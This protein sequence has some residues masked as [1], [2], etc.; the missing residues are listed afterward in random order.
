M[1]KSLIVHIG[2]HK[3]GSTAIQNALASGRIVDSTREVHYLSSPPGSLP[4]QNFLFNALR[5]KPQRSA[6]AH[7]RSMFAEIRRSDAP[8]SVISAEVLERVPA[9]AFAE[10]LQRE[11]RGAV[12]DVRIVAYC[13]PHLSRALSLFAEQSKIGVNVGPLDEFVRRMQKKSRLTYH[14]RFAAWREQFGDGLTVRPFVRDHLFNRSVVEDFAREAFGP[15]ASVSDETEPAGDNRSLG[16]VDLVT[17]RFVQSHLDLKRRSMRMNLGR[18]LAKQLGDAAAADATPLLLDRATAERL[19]RVC[20]DD[21]QAMDAD[22]FGA[23]GL[24][25][26]ALE[27]PSDKLTEVAQSLDPSDH[28]SADEIRRLEG[29][30]N[31]LG[32]LVVSSQ[33]SDGGRLKKRLRKTVRR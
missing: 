11:L 10:L 27:L 2:D 26:A 20:R 15:G 19:A 22:F 23:A 6:M 24:F 14:P 21:A 25:E 32:D 31:A 1:T 12:D 8:V 5:N 29:V 16:L 28:F 13:R 3:T 7:T 30:A 4:N 33:K 18:E 17:V 9:E